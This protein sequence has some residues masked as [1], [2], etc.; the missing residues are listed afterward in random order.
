MLSRGGLAAIC[1]LVSGVQSTLNAELFCDDVGAASASS[2]GKLAN[3]IQPSDHRFDDFI[4]PMSNFIFFEDPRTLTEAR[5]L[6]FNHKLPSSIGTLGLPGG[7]VQLYALQLRFAL[8]ERLSV[9]AVKDGFIVADIDGGPLDALLNDGWADVSAGL[10]YNLLS[11][12][13]KGNLLSAGFTYE[14]PIGST[15]ALQ[16][17]GDGEFHL[18]VSGGKRLLNGLAHYMGAVGYRIPVDSAVQTSSIH[19]SNHFDGKIT[20]NLYAFTEVVWWHWTDSADS[21]LPLGVGGQDPFNLSSTNVTGNNL[22]TQN[23]GIKLKPSGNVEL[24]VAYEFPLTAFQDVID[25]RIQAELI[26]RF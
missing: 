6:F 4:S 1:L 11:D 8:S 7:D 5:A 13:D 10:K 17:I 21:G 2:L 18:F 23:V 25:N 12:P 22:V 3:L 16:D 9:I 19:W 20:E 24:G 26:L 14:V 15:R